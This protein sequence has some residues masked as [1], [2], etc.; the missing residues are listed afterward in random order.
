MVDMV[1][2][3][4]DPIKNLKTLNH[5]Q[6]YYTIKCLSIGTPNTN[7]ISFVPNGKMMAID[8]V[9]CPNFGTPKNKKN[10]SNGKVIIFRCPNT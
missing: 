8:V 9:T 7:T 5:S 4:N 10:P 6:V 2:A 3:L 1:S